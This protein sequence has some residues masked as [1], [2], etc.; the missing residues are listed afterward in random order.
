[1]TKKKVKLPAKLQPWLEARQKYR[2][3]DRQI[4]MARELGLNPR[5]F[6]GYANHRQQS[7]KRPLGEYIE[8]LYVK[9]FKKEGPDRVT[10][11]EEQ[12]QAMQRKKEEK[13]A[14]KR[15]RQAMRQQSS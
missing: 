4:Q 13:K 9:R 8:H 14:R 3:T 6:G 15:A 11:L 2:L 7:W 10:S 12:A 1:M 5:K